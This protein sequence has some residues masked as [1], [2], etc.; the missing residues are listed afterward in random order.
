MKII[1]YSVGNLEGM[2]QTRKSLGYSKKIWFFPTIFGQL[3]IG[4]SQLCTFPIGHRPHR[5]QSRSDTDPIG[6]MLSPCAFN[7]KRSLLLYGST[8]VCNFTREMSSIHTALCFQCET[9]S[10]I[11]R[12]RVAPV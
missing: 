5:T 8:W 9:R 6:H 3:Q 2:Q 10:I 4:S 12:F 11:V 1:V 7:A